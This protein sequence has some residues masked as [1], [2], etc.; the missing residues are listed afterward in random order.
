MAC[1]TL[2]K[3]FNGTCFTGQRKYYQ[4]VVL[5]NKEDVNQSVLLFDI[6]QN[7]ANRVLFN[8]KGNLKG[9]RFTSA[10]NG[11]SILGSFGKITSGASVEYEHRL[12]IVMFGADEA[13][14]CLLRGL[15]FGNYFGAVQ[16]GKVVEI[17]GFEYGLTTDDYDWN[18]T[19]MGGAVIINL[20]SRQTALENSPPLVYFSNRGTA[21][22]DFNNLFQ[23]IPDLDFADYNDDYNNDFLI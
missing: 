5:V 11:T 9:F 2:K 19:E 13:T 8:L 1:I 21:I 3:G 22:E 10:V 18:I 4:E 7:C 6:Q 15:D 17:Y 16:I 12:Q 14:K 23:N 20:I